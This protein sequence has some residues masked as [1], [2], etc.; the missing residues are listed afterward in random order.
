[1]FCL[2]AECAAMN[3]VRNKDD[4]YQWIARARLDIRRYW[5]APTQNA[6]LQIEGLNDLVN[7]DISDYP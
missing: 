6:I 2:G 1:M 3:D 7:K 5:Y 4:E